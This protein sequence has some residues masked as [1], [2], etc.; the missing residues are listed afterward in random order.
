[1][2]ALIPLAF[3][4][5]LGCLQLTG[6]ADYKVEETPAAPVCTPPPGSTCR[7]GPN[8]GCGENETCALISVAGAGECQPA[9]TVPRGATCAMSGECGKGMVCINAFCQPYCG[10]DNDCDTKQCEGMSVDGKDIQNV[11][12][13][14]T[15]C[16]P[17]NDMCPAGTTCQLSSATRNSCL[18]PPP[19]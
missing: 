2:R 9:G 17:A 3:V 12:Y 16:D 19:A 13:C 1:M 15:P 7:V 14:A 4:M 18:P 8:C 5:S 10:T 6:V 11:G